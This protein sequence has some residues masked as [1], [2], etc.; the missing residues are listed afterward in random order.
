MKG[1]RIV[2]FVLFVL[3]VSIYSYGQSGKK[4]AGFRSPLDIPLYLSG[5]FGELRSGH[6]HSGIDIKTGGVTGKKVY[7]VADGYVSRIK[8]SLGGYGK[9]LYITHYNGYVSVY[10][11]LSGFNDTL[12][13][14]I[15]N[16]QY[17]RESYTVEIF[18]PKNR[19]RVKKGDVIAYTGNSGSSAGPHLHFEIREAKTQYPVNP[20]LFKNINVADHRHPLIVQ[21]AVYP[22]DDTSL[23]NGKN[24]TLI[25]PV[26]G[27]GNKCH[28]K[29]NQAINAHGNISF[30]I[31]TYDVM[32]KVRNKNGVYT[33]DVFIDSSEVFGLK[34]DKISF[35]TTR[36]I[37]SLIDYRYYQKKKRRIIRIQKDTNNRLFNYKKVE[38]SGVFCFDDEKKHKVVF[39]IK[40]IEGNGATLAFYV[41]G[42]PEPVSKKLVKPEKHPEN[43]VF[44]KFD[45]PLTVNG[46]HFTAKFPPKTFY[47]SFY[48]TYNEYDKT[49]TSYSKT[50]VLGSRFVP[51][52]KRFDFSIVPDTVPGNLKPKIYMGKID[53]DNIYYTG[54][55]WNGNKVTARIREF[56][57][58]ALFVDTIAP[59]I[60]PIDFPQ[61]KLPAN[62]KMLRI[63]IKDAQT[64]I[65]NYKATV[66]GKWLL[67]EY[68]LK[69]DLLTYYI[70][71]H[72]PE[73]KNDFK[74]T[75]TDNVGN[76][77]EYETVIVR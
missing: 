19:F 65:K 5:S 58:Y 50:I 41:K 45:K 66:N 67:M 13:N 30:G 29:N 68:D 63:K 31:R 32:D 36:Y 28:L 76:V 52:H 64:G 27:T 21:L 72:L 77:S 56:G 17:D 7:A 24:D 14:F 42:N 20:L 40:D 75:V 69:N 9:A 1:S 46:K 26:L 8:I 34:M 4:D 33:I 74:L 18:P 57:S 48:L 23:V 12:E 53:E 25:L 6:F 60:K 73:G 54:G 38:N 3:L 15:K 2:L 43:G 71:N 22:V 55:K 61:G 70:D 11:H 16:T 10:G 49:D 51:V 35:Y 37:N 59:E 39:R 44:V 47:R 62:Q